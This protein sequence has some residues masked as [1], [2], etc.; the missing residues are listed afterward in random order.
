M[1][2]P[3]DPPE[4][5]EHSMRR[6]PNPSS[7]DPWYGPVPAV[8]FLANGRY[9]V[10]LTP[11]G[12]GFSA[13]DDHALSRWRGDPV[14]DAD[15][16]FLY[17]RDLES[18]AFWSMGLQPA[19]VPASRYM[20]SWK[21]GVFR[22][23]REDGGIEAVLE[24]CVPPDGAL[25][26]RRL[27][28]R[29][30]SERPRRIELT[31]YVEV[32]LHHPAAHAA[33]P[34]FSKLF[35]QT[36]FAPGRGALW[37]R[38]RPRAADERHPCMFHALVGA[39]PTEYETDRARFWGRGARPGEP[40]AL[41]SRSPLSGTTGS[42][43]DPILSLRFQV[44]LAPGA[45]TGCTFLL[46]AASDTAEAQALLERFA[47]ADAE[48]SLVRAELFARSEIERFGMTVAEAEYFHSLAGA[49]LYGHPGLRVPRRT[50]ARS[51]AS[52]HAGAGHGGDERAAGH[53]TPEADLAPLGISPRQTL[54]VVHADQP[55]GAEL[56]PTLRQAHGYWLELGLPIDLVVL[57]GDAMPSGPR[58]RV[59][60]SDDLSPQQVD[61]LDAVARLVVIDALPDLASPVT[62]AGSGAV[63]SG[64][65]LA[66]RREKGSPPAT[67]GEEAQVPRVPDSARQDGVF[68]N[69]YG[70][71]RPDGGSYTIQLPRRDGRLFLPPQPWINVL[72][73]EEFGC[74]IS[75][76]GAGCTWSRNSREHRLTPWYNDP[77]LDPHGEALY[78]RDEESG[79]FW[80]VLPG[81]APGPGG[82]EVEHGLGFSRCIHASHGLQQETH[83]F[84][85][86]SRPLKISWLH[87]DNGSEQRRRLSLFAY[88]RLVLGDLP[89]ECARGIETELDAESG[90]VFARNRL[91]AEYGGGVAFAAIVAPGQP[92]SEHFTADRRSFIGRNGSPASPLAL[93]STE[94]LDGRA[95]VDLDPC[96]ALQRRFD[97]APGESLDVSLLFGEAEGV[98]DARRLIAAHAV[99]HAVPHALAV[100]TVGWGRPLAVQI[101]TP[102]PAIDFMVN[103][104]LPH[105]V[106]SCRMRARTAFQQ[107]G[108]AY[109]F[110]DQLQDAAALVTP[111]PQLTRAQLLLHAGHQFVEGDVL[112]W[113]HPPLGR[114]IRTRFADDLL[115]LPYLTAHYVGTTGDWG[116]LEEEVRFLSAR[117]LEPGEDEAYLLPQDS[118]ES[119]DL[120]EHCCRALDRS[121]GV[122]ERGLPLF[123]CGD[124]NDGMNRVGR[125]GR[126][127]SVWMGFFLYH[128][129][130]QFLPLCARRRD[131]AR[132]RSYRAHREALQA[133][134]NE[135]GWDGEWYR[136]GYYDDGTPLGSRRSDEC[137]IDA[138]V[139]AW[140]VISGAAPPERARQAMD[141]VERHLIS[142]SDGLIRLLDP[143]FDRTPHDPGYI[144]GYVPGVRENGG[145]YTHAALWV[146]RA[147]AELGRNDR[148][149]R[150]LEMLS[151]VT[152]TMTPE[153]VS[154]YQVEPYVV[155]ADVYGQPPHV[156]RGGW[157]WYTG[158]AGWMYRVALESVLGFRIVDGETLL[159]DPCVPDD[160]PRFK[161]TYRR[162][163]RMEYDIVAT[164]PH[165]R[166]RGVRAAT[167]DGA[168][169]PVENGAA[170][171]PLG[172]ES[173][174]HKIELVLG[175]EGGTP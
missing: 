58:C 20:A 23:I 165:R 55:A 56:L 44:E 84:V 72:A 46:G 39:M 16:F 172:H 65:R 155:A 26:L 82:Y 164:N 96:I 135:T 105:Q 149:A 48:D 49:M 145:Q 77:V 30:R 167:L 66:I 144:K 14:E 42:V 94:H 98:E 3:I 2:D 137:R 67:P 10:L 79:E 103:G 33:H 13:V 35:V 93:R 34:A 116:I 1:R 131:E 22:I 63:A 25:E 60:R 97:L 139:Q 19:L 152:R 115:W 111:L 69:G 119:A 166:G 129:L 76:T 31:S 73:N 159:L 32:V 89:E 120:Y 102:V 17:L 68:F 146:V 80:S 158:S 132:I 148:A 113:W 88:H 157:T 169:V 6:A 107:S 78:L 153:R 71:F 161:I 29:N 21:P 125:G 112:H 12:T 140:A 86:P 106:L 27:R 47:A 18:G 108:G 126:G 37:A 40:Q 173:G 150:L 100:A 95:G 15:G 59:F 118:G 45:S 168:P 61:L 127:E 101:E 151:P 92:G 175:R 142:E 62:A 99:R 174:F 41:V 28:L 8:R 9:R 171:I 114:G 136:R 4:L 36:E 57:G 133:A 90:A 160:W 154:T 75:E 38:R 24:A 87:I 163:P 162:D 121:L 11:A 138:L 110:R 104:W 83:V 147:L 70:A 52:R 50:G 64:P 124:W 117:V 170:R 122:G 130:G 81:P 109:G 74:L 53:R 43:L 91:D 156:G 85:T 54:A 51:A 123:G 141:A 143:P 7:L 134:L 5:R 128:V